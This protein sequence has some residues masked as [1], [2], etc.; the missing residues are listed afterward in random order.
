[1]CGRF[2]QRYT[3]REIHDLY[4]LTG[5]A[6]NLQ[7]HYNIAPTDTV[8]VVKLANGGTTELAPM[9]CGLIPYWWKKLL[10]QL[11]ATFNARAEGVAS[12]P[13]F[14]DA[15]KR[16]RCIVL[17]SGYCEWIAKSDGKQPYPRRP[18]LAVSAP[19]ALATAAERAW[20][21]GQRPASAAP[22]PV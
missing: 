7:A 6:R 2:T 10:K 4:D 18:D 17:A 3:W 21:P 12:K 19:A 9:R 16:H 20:A 11:P 15:F 22:A 1:M 14:R 5:T 13:M 8:D